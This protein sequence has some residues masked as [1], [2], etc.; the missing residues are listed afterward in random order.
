MKTLQPEEKSSFVLLGKFNSRRG[1][2][3]SSK[4]VFLTIFSFLLVFTDI[5]ELKW[6][7]NTKYYLSKKLI[8]IKHLTNTFIEIPKILSEYVDIKRE[9]E[10]LRL[11]IDELKIKTIITSNIERELEELKKAVNLKYSSDLFK[12]MEKVLGFDKSVHDSF[13]LISS[14][15]SETK[16][17]SVVISSEGL[18]G[19]IFDLHNDI[20][21]VLPITNHKLSIPVVTK[22]DGHLILSGTDTNK[23]ISK[24][25]KNNTV[26]EFQIGDILY[27]SG[28]GGIFESHIPVGEITEINKKT[29]EIIAKPLVQLKNIIFIWIVKQLN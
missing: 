27:T 12:T 28:E 14:T 19:I 24:E 26:D 9:N 16:E 3:H 1:I 22:N 13:L 25:V 4:F 21:R 23:L 20:A 17:G 18:V 11:E 29:N 5:C 8:P 15:T 7:V 2:S 6:T 10:K